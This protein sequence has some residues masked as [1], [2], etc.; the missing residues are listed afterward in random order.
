M[1]EGKGILALNIDSTGIIRPFIV[2]VASP[3]VRGFLNKKPVHDVFDRNTVMQLSQPMKN[4]TAAVRS[5]DGGL[6]IKLDSDLYNEGRFA[7]FQYP[8]IIYNEQIRSI[9]TKDFLATQEKDTF[10]E[11]GVL[12]LNRKMEE[13]TSVVR[14]FGRHVVESLRPRQDWYKSKWVWIAIIVMVAILALMFAP[15]IIS[16]VREFTATAGSSFTNAQASGAITP[17]G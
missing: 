5:N 7:L 11:H 8:V 6:T 13:L 10:A 4:E 1:I 16:T 3:Y 14:D 9:I 17:R 12:Y 2:R 15:V